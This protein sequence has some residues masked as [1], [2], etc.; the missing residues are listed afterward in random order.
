MYAVNEKS[1][2]INIKG[3]EVILRFS[4]KADKMI[5][6]QN[7]VIDMLMSAFESRVTEQSSNMG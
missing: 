7:K 2:K 3:C 1:E 4:S 6:T 5:D